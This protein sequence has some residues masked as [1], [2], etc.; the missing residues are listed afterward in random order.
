MRTLQ[1]TPD[2]YG[3]HLEKNGTW[4]VFDAY[5]GLSPEVGLGQVRGM[6]IAD[7]RAMMS[8][9]NRVHPANDFGKIH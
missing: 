4:T 5:T 8:V 3:I 6:Q 1:T 9:L 2:R 7:A